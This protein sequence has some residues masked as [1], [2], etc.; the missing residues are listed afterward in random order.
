MNWNSANMAKILIVDDVKTNLLILKNI[1]TTYIKNSIIKTCESP[2]KVIEEVKSFEPDVILLDIQMPH[3]NGFEL[4]AELKSEEKTKHIPIAFITAIF[5]DYKSKIKGLSLG[6]DAFL[7]KPI[8]AGELIAQLNV[9]I[10][11]KRIEDKLK[12]KNFELQQL[13]NKKSKQLNESQE[14][15]KN[16]FDNN[17]II[18]LLI[19]PNSLKIV[20]ANPA[21]IKFYGYNNLKELSIHDISTKP[22]TETK[23]KFSGIKNHV[24]K[25]INAE[26]IVEGGLVK[27]VLIHSRIVHIERK[28]TLFSIIIDVTD[29]E[30]QEKKIEDAN[31][32]NQQLLEDSP[33]GIIVYN[34]KG[35]CIKANESAAKILGANDKAQLL[36]QNFYEIGPWKKSGL[37]ELAEEVLTQ[38]TKK[39]ELFNM[40]TSFGIY[41][42]VEI[43]LSTIKMNNQTN[44]VLSLNDLTDNKEYEKIIQNNLAYQELIS[45]IAIKFNKATNTISVLDS[46]LPMILEFIDASCISIYKIDHNKKIALKL[47][48]HNSVKENFSY[49]NGSR[50]INCED[51]QVLVDTFKSIEYIAFEDINDAPIDIQK[52]FITR[53]TKSLIIFPLFINYKLYG[54]VFFEEILY[55]RKWR[56]IHIEVLKSVSSLISNALE[57]DHVMEV[58]K[59]SE[60]KFRQLSVN[61]NDAVILLQGDSIIYSN[62]AIKSIFAIEELPG[63]ANIRKYYKFLKV[64]NDNLKK[65]FSYKK[66]FEGSI[67]E[68]MK[69]K[70]HT[71]K[72]KWIWIRSFL[73]KDEQDIQNRKVIIITDISAR[74]ELENKI[75]QTVIQ[76]EEIER[77]R[78]AVDLHDGIGP[79]LSSIKLYANLFK[80]KLKKNNQLE[81][82]ELIKNIESIVKEAVKIT[83]SVANDIT[84]SLL[85][86][87]GIQNAI[88]QYIARINKTEVV[89][90]EFKSN[91]DTKRFNPEIEINTY[92]MIKELI[93]NSVKHAGCKKILI[94]MDYKD[95]T[96]SIEYQ[97]DGK[98]FDIEEITKNKNNGLGINSLR[99]RA[100][101]ANGEIY[102]KSTKGKGFSAKI[103]LKT[104]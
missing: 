44:L 61:I 79:L 16:V 14:F 39:S 24:F 102:F 22:N 78:F 58:L 23:Q 2:G 5:L 9:L 53:K 83:R 72:E 95:Q 19:D 41:I 31:T 103:K 20:D 40:I 42:W 29:Q 13:L 52:I 18:M 11:I 84:P 49:Y 33:Y 62:P 38:H 37:L 85:N 75:I 76:T 12:K 57:R 28:K 86:D 87:Y 90:I 27:Q 73:I 6:A 55:Y 88:E 70:L 30:E 94:L 3:K 47:A 81:Y 99:S 65:C 8:D 66:L 68:E 32:F 26:H 97:D 48:E 46:I 100:K 10:R 1:I 60:E 64:E 59:T 7:T 43:S 98:G 91:I 36:S 56:K 92:R 45:N 35:D 101:S 104:T 15:Y 82:L 4:C 54:F 89:S 67:N 17:E 96:L 21:A 69:I 93:N 25:G 50:T 74:K 77:K 63:E 34:E 80:V 51:C 71:K